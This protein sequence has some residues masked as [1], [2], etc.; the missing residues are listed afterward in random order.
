MYSLDYHGTHPLI[1]LDGG[2]CHNPD[3]DGKYG[4]YENWDEGKKTI[5]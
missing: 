4:G 5:V 3:C 2:R 1:T